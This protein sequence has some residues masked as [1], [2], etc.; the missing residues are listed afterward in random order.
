MTN[1]DHVQSLFTLL[2]RHRVPMSL[3]RYSEFQKDRQEEDPFELL[4]INIS[5]LFLVQIY[6]HAIS[7]KKENNHEAAKAH[8]SPENLFTT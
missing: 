6:T 4:N 5:F 1:R 8:V 3:R 7:T 2:D